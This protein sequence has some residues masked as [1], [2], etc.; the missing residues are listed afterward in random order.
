[1]RK[2]IKKTFISCMIL[3]LAICSLTSCD[4][5]GVP[6]VEETEEGIIFEGHLYVEYFES[7]LY[8]FGWD[9]FA[10]SETS[11]IGRQ[12]APITDKVYV[13]TA[14]T[15]DNYVVLLSH[16]DDTYGIDRVWVRE[17]YT[18]PEMEDCFIKEIVLSENDQKHTVGTFEKQTFKIDNFLYM[19]TDVELPIFTKQIGSLDFILEEY[20]DFC[21]YDWRIYLYDDNLYVRVLFEGF[22]FQICQVREEFASIIKE[23]LLLTD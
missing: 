5:N 11:M 1:M 7:E 6:Y 9:P 19:E 17:D 10:L 3:I 4:T 21:F 12:K 15:D 18:F 23:A 22:H 8:P 14:G 20:D 13:Y 2:V 16:Q